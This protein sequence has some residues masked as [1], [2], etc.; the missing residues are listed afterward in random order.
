MIQYHVSQ[1]HVWVVVTV[2][3]DNIE[4]LINQQS[5]YRTSLGSKWTVQ[6]NVLYQKLFTLMLFLRFR[7]ELLFIM[8]SSLVVITNDQNK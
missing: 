4:K 5:R 1:Q 7:L 2:I 3:V 6:V 8:L